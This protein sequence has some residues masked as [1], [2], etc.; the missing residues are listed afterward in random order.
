LPDDGS[1]KVKCLSVLINIAGFPSPF[2]SSP[3]P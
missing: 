3:H 2:F 1:A